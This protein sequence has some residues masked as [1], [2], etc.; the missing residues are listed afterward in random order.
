[1]K[2]QYPLLGTA[3]SVVALLGTALPAWADIYSNPMW[4]T[5]PAND[6]TIHNGSGNL[7]V[8][9][10]LGKPLDAAA[11]DYVQL[12]LDGKVVADSS[13][14]QHFKLKD[15]PL[16]RHTLEADLRSGRDHALLR[17]APVVVDMAPPRG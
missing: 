1:M 2:L 4:I 17:S 15:V 16:G 6:A 9:V 12:L 7:G 13:D 10:A 14:G 8:S 3:L 11:G 5:K